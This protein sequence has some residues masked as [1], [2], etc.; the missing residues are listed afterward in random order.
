[1]TPTRVKQGFNTFEV[2]L[3][4][5]TNL[6]EAAAKSIVAWVWADSKVHVTDVAVA[7]ALLQDMRANGNRL[8]TEDEC[9]GLVCEEPKPWGTAYPNTAK[10]LDGVLT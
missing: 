7:V 5:L 1:M 6:V 2:E 3:T 8:P 9:Q 4:G 10:L